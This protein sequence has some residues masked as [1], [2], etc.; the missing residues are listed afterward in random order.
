[1]G[2]GEHT[3]INLREDSEEEENIAERK[4]SDKS[5][6][7]EQE[8]IIASFSTPSSKHLPQEVRKHLVTTP[9][10]PKHKETGE[11]PMGIRKRCTQYKRY[12]VSAL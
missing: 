11:S 4:E 3:K 5:K 12:I 7:K 9:A 6:G 8:N 10:V 2:R 1:M